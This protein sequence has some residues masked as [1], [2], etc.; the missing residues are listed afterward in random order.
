MNLGSESF[1][2]FATDGPSR[3]KM[4]AVFSN[5]DTKKLY[6]PKSE[7]EIDETC[8]QIKAE[9]DKIGDGKFNIEEMREALKVRFRVEN[10]PELVKAMF[11]SA[12]AIENT[13]KD[14]KR[15][16]L[17]GCPNIKTLY[18]VLMMTLSTLEE[19]GL[20]KILTK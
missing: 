11:M 16:G 1:S 10:N 9:L 17:D 5:I 3:D 18:D 8:D 20:I 7:K 15:D 14:A 13:L 2:D 6:A 12:S 4:K 19:K